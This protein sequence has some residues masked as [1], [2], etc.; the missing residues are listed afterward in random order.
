MF[1]VRLKPADRPALLAHLLALGSEDRRLRFGFIARDTSIERYVR[2]ID[3]ERHAVFGVHG[4]DQSFDGI[5]HLALEQRHAEIGVSVLEHARGH[6]I[7]SALVSRAAMH[8]RN[9]S[10]EVLYMQCLSENSAIMRIARTL[11][12]KVI[13]V[14]SDSEAHLTLPAANSASIANEIAAEQIALYDAALCDEWM[15]TTSKRPS[16]APTRNELL[17]CKHRV[18]A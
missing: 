5:T 10:I 6:G 17:A 18:A 2:D 16:V 13:T 7:G 1:T 11:G 14:G 9:R 12:M 15:P 4:E 8:A 3:F